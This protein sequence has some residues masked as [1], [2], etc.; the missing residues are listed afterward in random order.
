MF[1]VAV[2]LLVVLSLLVLLLLLLLLLLLG[3][4]ELEDGKRLMTRLDECM[5]R[6]KRSLSKALTPEAADPHKPVEV[7]DEAMEPEEPDT[8]P[9]IT[10]P[11]SGP[12]SVLEAPITCVWEELAECDVAPLEMA[13]LKGKKGV[14]SVGLTEIFFSRDISPPLPPPLPVPVPVVPPCCVRSKN[15]YRA[16]PPPP[17]PIVLPARFPV[18]CC[19]APGTKLRIPKGVWNRDNPLS[20][21]SSV[22]SSCVRAAFVPIS[23]LV[24]TPISALVCLSACVWSWRMWMGLW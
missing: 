18:E 24:P 7:L 19:S 5:F 21:C 17:V 9:G 13:A 22:G 8:I 20:A 10:G 1:V 6:V 15:A 11:V 2:L 16:P 14:P 4:L 3:V 23:T 12:E